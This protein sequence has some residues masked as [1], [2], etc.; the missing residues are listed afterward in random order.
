[1]R[2]DVRGP[3]LIK[4]W[5]VVLIFILCARLLV[6][7]SAETWRDH[8]KVAKRL[9]LWMLSL[10]V[11]HVRRYPS[12]LSPIPSSTKV[13]WF[14]YAI[15]VAL[16]LTCREFWMWK[17]TNLELYF[18]SRKCRDLLRWP[19]RRIPSAPW[20]L[21]FAWASLRRYFQCP[22]ARARFQS[23]ERSTEITL[24]TRDTNAGCRTGRSMTRPQRNF[25][26]FLSMR[27][28]SYLLR[29]A[30]SWHCSWSGY[31]MLRTV[32]EC[33][34]QSTRRSRPLAAS[35]YTWENNLEK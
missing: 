14:I 32:K 17:T 12:R 29:R 20:E 4:Y 34:R 3:H 10:E 7:A 33:K 11:F 35:T 23:A 15:V 21:A 18:S 6:S 26:A 30:Y 2:P 1:M 22:R 24:A 27:E 16:K 13:F 8:V 19:Q 28:C 31:I 25:T 9:N 5:R